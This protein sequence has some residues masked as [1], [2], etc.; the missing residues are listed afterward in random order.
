MHSALN[1]RD[2]L[3]SSPV[4]LG[5]LFLKPETVRG[6][7]ANSAVSVGLVG[8]GRRGN[9]VGEIF[10]KRKDAAIT[11]IC[12]IYDDMLAGARRLFPAART[13]KKYDDMLAAPI[14]AVL[15]A[16]P[17]HVRP[18]HFEAAVAARKHIFME[19]PV[20]VDAAACRRVLA[21]ARKAD[22]SKR[23]SVDF[24]QR[25]GK[26]YRKARQILQ[27][28]QLGAMR[29]IRAAWMA[30]AIPYRQ[31][32]TPPEEKMRN[33]LFYRD[34]SGDIVVEQDCHNFDVVNWFMG[35]HPLSVS[36]Y[37]GRLSYKIG[38]IMDHLA[39]TFR[40]ANGIVFS[41]AANQFSTRGYRDIS[42][43]FIGEKG[44]LTTSRQG[45]VHYDKIVD[46]NLPPRGYVIPTGKDA[47]TVVSTNYDITDDAVAE[48]V[49]G[50]RFNRLENAA[51][52]A[53]E[54]MYTAIM[55]RTAIYTGKEVTWEEIQQ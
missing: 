36:G 44:A 12:D 43:T 27:S 46:E 9:F 55:A 53:V 39:C 3:R 18:D 4:G 21:A 2:L 38:D 22:K 52:S 16:T 35:A 37:G 32:V 30:G 15:I 34:T 49:E 47:P 7:Q 40:F 23:I 54:T 45:Y 1:R 33:W 42:E 6:S 25:Y 29:M 28:G 50:V 24:Q 41:Y 11:A 31:G 5:L 20:A 48:F 51:F 13:C 19:K 17:P 26:D 10:A 14:D 8:C